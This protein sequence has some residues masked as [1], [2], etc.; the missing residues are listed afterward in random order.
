MNSE[1][2]NLLGA[3]QIHFWQYGRDPTNFSSMLL[4][5]LQKSDAGNRAK[6]KAGWPEIYNA[7][8][9]W[10]ACDSQDEFFAR[11]NLVVR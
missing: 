11:Y 9:E 7:W 3:Q 4:N 10:N 8:E 2:S 5:L 6:I 1:G